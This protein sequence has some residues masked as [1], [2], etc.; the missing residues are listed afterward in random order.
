MKRDRDENQEA[1]QAALAALAAGLVIAAVFAVVFWIKSGRPAQEALSLEGRGSRVF[2]ATYMTMNNPFYEIIDDEIR[3][4]L[5]GQGDVL[6]TRDPALSVEK[7]IDQVEELIDRKVD[8][9]FINPVDWK[10]ISPALENARRAGIPVIAVDSDVYDS[11]LVECT[12]TTDN[13]Q[14]GV[15]CA[16]HLLATRE[17]GSILLLTHNTAKSGL[18]RI[19]GFRDTIQGRKGFVILDERDCLGQ[20]ELAMP[21]M[22]E[23]LALYPQVDIVMCLNDVAAMGAMAALEDAG[24]T[25]SVAV[26]GVDGSPDGKAMIEEHIM[27]ATAAQFPRK[28]GREAAEA[29]Y[30]IVKGQETAPEIKVGTELISWENLEKYGTDGWQ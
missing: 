4:V 26:Y 12:V 9:I 14:A 13:Y 16:R 8:G 2:G 28:M 3:S 6:I 7:Q 1:F 20:L 17:G 24:R 10:G 19:Q 30:R 15:L 11:E 23:L 22:K 27:T 21:A 25:G 18:D 29:A 5:E